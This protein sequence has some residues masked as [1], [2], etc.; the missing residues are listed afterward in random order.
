MTIGE[1]DMPI[2]WSNP[3]DSSPEVRRWIQSDYNI[4]RI[5]E[6]SITKRTHSRSS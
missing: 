1:R 4:V 6:I 5:T 2:D 3:G